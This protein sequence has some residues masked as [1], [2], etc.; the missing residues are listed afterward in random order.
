MAIWQY[1]IYLLPR[2]ELEAK[3]GSIPQRLTPAE[4]DEV[5]FWQARQPPADVCDRFSHWRKEIKA[6]TP[7]LRWWGFEDSDRV[8]LWTTDGRVSTIEFRIELRR[9]DMSFIQLIVDLARDSECML[10]S[11]HSGQLIEPLRDHV[12]N[13]L[14]K[15]NGVNE[16]W[17]WIRDPQSTPPERQV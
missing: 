7:E 13:H 3:F 8:D 14:R 9:L 1:D 15:S 11:A 10:F 4:F 6:W 16:V 12:L 2:A 5:G 17:D